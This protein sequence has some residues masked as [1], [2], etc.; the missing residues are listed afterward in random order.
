MDPYMNEHSIDI[1]C[2]V[3]DTLFLSEIWLKFI[4]DL[5]KDHRNLEKCLNLTAVLKSV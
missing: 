4:S 5:H 2:Q 1:M 3:N